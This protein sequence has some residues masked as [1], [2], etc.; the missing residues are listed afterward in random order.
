MTT[1][2]H[3]ESWLDAPA[4]VS[5]RA[6]GL[7]LLPLATAGWL[8]WWGTA[9]L[10]VLFGLAVRWP[11]WE[12]GRL[13]LSLLIVGGA[14][15]ALAPAALATGRT[16]LVGLAL[17]YLA[18][19]FVALALNWTASRISD[20]LRRSRTALLAP[21]L[22]GLLA[23]Q[24]GL[25]L[26]L[27]GGLLAVP[28][29]DERRGS[30]PSKPA[31]RVWWTVGAALAVLLICSVLLPR[32]TV[33]WADP[34]KPPSP[35]TVQAS[36][37]AN[38]ATPPN[39]TQTPAPPATPGLQLPFQFSINNVY[40][41]ID[42][43]LLVG[44]LLL[45]AGGGLMMRFRQQQRRKLR[46][47]EMLM[48]A[49]LLLTGALWLAAGVLLSGGDGGGSGAAQ[50]PVPGRDNALAAMLSNITGRRQIDISGFVQ[51]LLWLSL[52][53]LF[54]VAAA[55]F[56]LNWTQNRLKDGEEQDPSGPDTRLISSPH[57]PLHRV[58]LAYRQAEEAL[59]QHGRGRMAAETPAGYAARLSAL[60]TVLTGPLDTL[61]RAYGPV[62][63]GGRV[64]DEDAAGAEAATHELVTVL[65]TLPPPHDPPDEASLANKENP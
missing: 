18:L 32:Q 58:R 6:Y 62:R 41:P 50:Q 22:I 27:A 9:L 7:A 54:L 64:T 36:P 8:P 53:V 5:W 3:E 31:S 21:L 30:G 34:G 59:R 2:P 16:A 48:V 63:Y 37:P 55:L 29:R 65:P 1:A 15:V 47:I 25:V 46:L 12:E 28:G 52:V 56:R 40:L 43:I 10:C 61:T 17:H 26:A 45:L 20:G 33:N 14:A 23:P 60:D 4:R 57:A 42:A 49:G 19:F 44:L 38:Q 35:S 11:R 51:G 24:P 13:L 39:L